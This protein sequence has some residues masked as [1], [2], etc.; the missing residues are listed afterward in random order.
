M[1]TSD[2][3]RGKDYNHSTFL[4]LIIEGLVGLQASLGAY[5]VRVCWT[6]LLQ[7]NAMLITIRLYPL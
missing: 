6:C 7:F 5:L 1:P 4:D 3:D 2:K